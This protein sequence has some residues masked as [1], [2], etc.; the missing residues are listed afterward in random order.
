MNK[1]I[2]YH[3]QQD[4]R[5]YYKKNNTERLFPTVTVLFT[6]WTLNIYLMSVFTVI[7]L[8]LRVR[9]NKY[10]LFFTILLPMRDTDLSRSGFYRIGLARLF[11]VLRASFVAQQVPPNN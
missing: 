8:F 6:S 10:Y 5:N 9:R 2:E 11:V 1:K 7:N 4:G 3:N